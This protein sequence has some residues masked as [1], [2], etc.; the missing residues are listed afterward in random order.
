[1]QSPGRLGKQVEK[2]MGYTLFS[3]H[4]AWKFIFIQHG[5]ETQLENELVPGSHIPVTDLRENQHVSSWLLPIYSS[6][7][8]NGEYA[9][10]EQAEESAKGI[11][12]FSSKFGT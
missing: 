8:K 1:M 11:L 3:F 10:K 4:S 2:G 6:D 7:L 9:Q 12:L 5:N